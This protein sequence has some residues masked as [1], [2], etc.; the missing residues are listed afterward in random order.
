MS[1]AFVVP[2]PG[3]TM[4]S[5]TLAWGTHSDAVRSL[6]EV[7]AREA[8]TSVEELT[9]QGGRVA[10]PAQLLDPA[11]T[12]LCLGIAGELARHEVRPDIVAGYSLG[13]I[14]ACCVAGCLTPE[15]AVALA[16]ERGRLMAREAARYPG[17]VVLLRAASREIAEEAVT[18]ARSRGIAGISA[19]RAPDLWA[20]AG[21]W[22]ALNFLALGYRYTA[23]WVAGPWHCEILRGAV[24]E[25]RVATRRV[26]R[27]SSRV[28]VVAGSTGSVATG[29]R[30][31]AD[32]LADQ[33]TQPVE[34]VK[35][36][37]SL[38][39]LGPSDLVALGP[40]ETWRG[41]LPV[42]AEGLPVIH[43]AEVV[44]DLER[45]LPALVPRRSG[46]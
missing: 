5:A 29:A 13:D 20:V 31:L 19:H 24:E 3:I 6:L 36:M 41:L 7:A 2:S 14:A 11:H 42:A 46:T 9:G 16:A 17:G 40:S 8:G 15:E 33:L 37:E 21:Q 28:P 32:L 23:L 4:S 34:W 27:E 30:E 45:I 43:S 38:A 25:F 10:M 39:A 22:S 35:V 44:S 1:V 12:A 26:F 18:Y